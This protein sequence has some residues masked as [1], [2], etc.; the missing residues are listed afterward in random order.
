MPETLVTLGSILEDGS[1]RLAAAGIRE[2]RR[3][4][5]LIWAALAGRTP[6]ESVLE[7]FQPVCPDEAGGLEAAFARR[8]GGEPLAYVT[9]RAGFRHLDLVVDA[10]V[11]IP[12]PETEGLVEGVLCRVRRG[13]VVD[14]GTGSGCIALSLA[15]EGDFAEVV[16]VDSSAAARG[17]ARMNRRALGLPVRLIRGDLVSAFAPG[18]VDAIVSNPPYLSEPEY[19]ALGSSV[20]DW[21]PEAALVSGADGLAATMALLDDGRRVLRP[22]GWV[23]VEVDCTRAGLAAEHALA[24]GWTDVAVEADLFGRERFLFA[25]RSARS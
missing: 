15:S 23:A 24:L 22:G 3:E 1:R 9:G 16:G 19:A 14:V 5:S 13:T 12:R 8:A 11:L 25:R 10:R 2:P 21:E 17:V 20:R 4:A 18:S 7:R 6:G